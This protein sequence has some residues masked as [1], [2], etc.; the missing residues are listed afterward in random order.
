MFK[1]VFNIKVSCVL[2]FCHN[3]LVLCEEAYERGEGTPLSSNKEDSDKLRRLALAI[4]KYCEDNNYTR[5]FLNTKIP[6]SFT[7]LASKYFGICK[8]IYEKRIRYHHAPIIFA[9]VL[10]RKLSIENILPSGL[11]DEIDSCITIFQN[12]EIL[13]KEQIESKLRKGLVRTKHT[14]L[15]KYIDCVDAIFAEINK[16]KQTKRKKKC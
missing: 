7:P 5:D 10:L 13:E 16:K 2:A 1:N 15:I 3:H 14:E 4:V 11:E 9:M 6:H 8:R 12:S